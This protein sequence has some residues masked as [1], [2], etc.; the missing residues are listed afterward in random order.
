[1]SQRSNPPLCFPCLECIMFLCSFPLFSMKSAPA[2]VR[3][4][5]KLASYWSAL[6]SLVFLC[7]YVFQTRKWITQSQSAFLRLF[8]VYHFWYSAT[9][10]IG[11]MQPG[12]RW[13]LWTSKRWG[14]FFGPLAHYFIQ[15]INILLA[16]ALAPSRHLDLGWNPQWGFSKSL[17]FKAWHSL[18]SLTIPFSCFMFQPSSHCH[19]ICLCRAPRLFICLLLVSLCGKQ[20]PCSRVFVCFAHPSMSCT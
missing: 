18:R 4:S 3:S 13:S 5:F 12:Q 6:Q 8:C 19:Q 15:Q 20:A 7:C 14:S 11:C 16:D 10:H 9:G 2:Y 17:F 1:M